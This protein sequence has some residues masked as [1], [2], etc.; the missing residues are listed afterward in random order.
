[1]GSHSY[2]EDC[3]KCGSKDSL[4]CCSETKS[5]YSSGEC[6]ECGYNFSTDERRMDLEVVNFQRHEMELSPIEKLKDYFNSDDEP[7][8]I[9]TISDAL[10]EAR[11]AGQWSAYI[12]TQF[13]MVLDMLVKKGIK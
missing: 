4:M 8:K 11:D 2:S 7:K 1:M 3:P 5:V 6:L 10:R 12:Y 9:E 13:D